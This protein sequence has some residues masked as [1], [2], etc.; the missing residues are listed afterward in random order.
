MNIKN[1]AIKEA[2]RVRLTAVV[3]N[4]QVGAALYTNSKVYPGCNQ[5]NRC[6]K[7]YHAEELA[8]LNAKLNYVHPED[9]KGLVVTFSSDDIDSLTFC[10]G[11]CRQILW[12]YTLNPDLL[13]SEV[14]LDGKIIDEKTLG[15]LYPYPYPRKGKTF[16]EVKIKLKFPIEIKYLT[17]RYE[18]PN[19]GIEME[20]VNKIHSSVTP[21]C[22]HFIC[23]TC[24]LEYCTYYKSYWGRKPI[25]KEAIKEIEVL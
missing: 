11:F 25:N 12:E 18:C 21:P 4:T 23:P 3:R 16:N 10:C 20:K 9:I 24:K 7:G 15:E 1:Q 17:T 13:I 6:H 19:C 22:C 2:L 8:V 5:E 14:G